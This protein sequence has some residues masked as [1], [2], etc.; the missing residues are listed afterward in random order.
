LPG[1]EAVA[2]WKLSQETARSTMP[3][4][5][6]H[7]TGIS[8]VSGNRDSYVDA[9]RAWPGVNHIAAEWSFVPLKKDPEVFPSEGYLIKTRNT[10]EIS[11]TVPEA[12]MYAKFSIASGSDQLTLRTRNFS[13]NPTYFKLTAIE[14]DGTVTHVEP[15]SN[16]AQSASAAT[17]GVWKFS[18]QD[19][20]AGNPEGYASFVY[21]L[22]QFDGKNVT[23]VYGVYNGEA[24]SGENKLV[25]YSIDLN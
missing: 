21:D 3:Q 10:P 12:Y 23:L 19:G 20:G 2:G 8:P 15:S 9:Y 6:K 11:T 14:D 13:S 24:N 1:T 16:T 18:H 5:K 25:F 17:D 22:S 4:T 7:F